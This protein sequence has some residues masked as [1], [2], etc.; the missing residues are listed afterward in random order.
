MKVIGKKHSKQ[1]TLKE[2]LGQGS[3]GK[4][5]NSP[6]YAIKEINFQGLPPFIT[7]SLKN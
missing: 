2:V 4:V 3:F 5:Y 1:Y 7:N 6:P